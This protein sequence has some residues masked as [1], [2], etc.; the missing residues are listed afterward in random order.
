MKPILIINTD[1]GWD[2][3]ACIL[4]ADAMTEDQYEEVVE[5]CERANLVMIDWQSVTSV[6]SFLRDYE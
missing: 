1:L 4:D 3:V 5:V 2:N 6:E